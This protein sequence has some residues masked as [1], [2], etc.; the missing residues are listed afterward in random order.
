[1]FIAGRGVL[2]VLLVDCGM[3]VALSPPRLR[4][5]GVVCWVLKFGSDFRYASWFTPIP[6][7][8]SKSPNQSA[9]AASQETRATLVKSIGKTYRGLMGSSGRPVTC[10]S[11]SVLVCRD[12][13][14]C[15]GTN[16]R[17]EKL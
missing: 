16:G 13:G 15:R 9:C 6:P 5:R 12:T 11:F 1:M 2:K 14:P 3:A 7:R 4:S 10:R 8:S 17:Q